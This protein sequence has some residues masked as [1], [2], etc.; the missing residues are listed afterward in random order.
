[1]LEHADGAQIGRVGLF[2]R[3]RRDIPGV[4]DRVRG[5]ASELEDLLEDAGYSVVKS[6]RS[7]VAKRAAM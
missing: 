2:R 3:E 4:G 1:M 6:E 5:A 7:A